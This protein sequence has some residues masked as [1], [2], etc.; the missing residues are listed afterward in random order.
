MKKRAFQAFV[1]IVMLVTSFASVGGVSAGSRCASNFV[2]Q[3]GDTLSGIA[4]FC[5]TTI[6]AIQAANPGLGSW[7]YAGQ[8]IHIPNGSAP[9]PPPQYNGTY[10]VRWGDTIGKIA[11]RTG[12]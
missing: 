11:A 3:W 1:A 7:V 5:G 2:V 12:T 6:A 4:I 10:M 9:V 8:T